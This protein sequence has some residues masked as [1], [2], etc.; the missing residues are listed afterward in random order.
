LG[1]DTIHAV[2]NPLQSFAG[3]IHVYGG[4]LN[5]KMGRSEWSAATLEEAPYNFENTARY[6]AVAND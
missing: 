3:A 1:P 5:N 4:D 2:T 6:F